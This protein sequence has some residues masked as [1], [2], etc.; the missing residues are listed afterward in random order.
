GNCLLKRS[1]G[2]PQDLETEMCD[3]G[4]KGRKALSAR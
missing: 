3:E 1:L 4:R 2:A